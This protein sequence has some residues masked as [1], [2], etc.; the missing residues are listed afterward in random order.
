MEQIPPTK[1]AIVSTQA[2]FLRGLEALILSMEDFSLVGRAENM[3]EATALIKLARPAFLLLDMHDCQENLKA[4]VQC[5]RE[6]FPQGTAVVCISPDADVPIPDQLEGVPIYYFSRNITEDE[7]KAALRYA[8]HE[9]DGQG[10]L[11]E[12]PIAVA[13]SQDRPQSEPGIVRHFT[14]TGELGKSEIVQRELVMAGRIQSDILPEKEPLIPG[15][16]IAARLEPARETSG[17]FYDFIPL[18]EHKMGIV[19]ADV[20]DKGM[21]AALFMVLSNTLFR[22]YAA[23][24]PTLPAVVLSAVSER[25]LRDTRSGMFVT[26]I[27]GV[28]EGHTGRI[29]FANAGHPPGYLIS[30]RMGKENVEYLRPTGMALGVSDTARWKQKIHRFNPGDV[31]VLYTDGVTEAQNTFGEYFGE[32]RI[33]ELV[34]RKTGSTAAEIREALLDEVHN[35]TGDAS[36]RDDIALIVIR[37]TE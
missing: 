8:R 33:I 1:I 13:V 36:G 34:F 17:D 29:V 12:E 24:F 22:T 16:E 4:T 21:G 18:T 28:L 7:F 19:I 32:E 35:F 30:S 31:L 27:F 37:R 14:Q 20:T 25:I 3:E 23:R 11:E 10:Q 15:W 2:I 6:Q 5:I 9:L 26:A